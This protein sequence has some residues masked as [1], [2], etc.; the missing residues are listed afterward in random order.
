M[1]DEHSRPTLQDW[2]ALQKLESQCVEGECKLIKPIIIIYFKYYRTS[3]VRIITARGKIYVSF[4]ARSHQQ[5]RATPGLEQHT[6]GR[7][8]KSANDLANSAEPELSELEKVFVSDL[9]HWRGNGREFKIDLTEELF[10]HWVKN[11]PQQHTIL[12]ACKYTW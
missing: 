9:I 11:Y 3:Y 12:S 6:Y 7:W 4:N 2:L 5:W 10:G 8:S 1:R